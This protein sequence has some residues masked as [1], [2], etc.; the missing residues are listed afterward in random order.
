MIISVPILNTRFHLW[1]LCETGSWPVQCLGEVTRSQCFVCH[2]KFTCDIFGTLG[3]NNLITVKV[4]RVSNK[5]GGPWDWNSR[6]SPV[7]TWY[8]VTPRFLFIPRI[9]S[10]EWGLLRFILTLYPLIRTSHL[11]PVW[12]G[13][14]DEGNIRAFREWQY[15]MR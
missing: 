9:S 6:T 15:M 4:L 14:G 10:H 2:A 13:E 7:S 11:Q 8:L 5:L 12:R 1:I 3:Q